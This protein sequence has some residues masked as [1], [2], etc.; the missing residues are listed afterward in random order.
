MSGF[1]S[2]LRILFY[3]S[4]SILT[5]VPNCFDYFNFAVTFEIRKYILPILW[6][7]LKTGLATVGPLHFPTN[8]RMN[9]A[10]FATT[11]KKKQKTEKQLGLGQGLAESANRFRRVLTAAASSQQT[12]PSSHSELNSHIIHSGRSF[13]TSYVE[14]SHGHDSTSWFPLSSEH[15]LPLVVTYVSAVS[16]SNR[17][18]HQGLFCLTPLL[19][20]VRSF[21]VCGN[22]GYIKHH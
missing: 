7:V 2:G 15:W 18:W 10:I 11:R 21:H 13:L 1:I 16:L 5:P 6:V 9:L 3:R 12:C 19:P 8:F 14:C 22:Q 17:L 4:M 20:N